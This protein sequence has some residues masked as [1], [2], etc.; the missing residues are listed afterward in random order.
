[1]RETKLKRVDVRL[2]GKRV[3]FGL[4]CKVV[5][6][7]GEPAIGALSQRGFEGVEMFALA[8]DVVG[9]FEGGAARV[10][11]VELPMRNLVVWPEFCPDVDDPSWPEI[12]EVEFL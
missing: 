12:G 8:S 4:A 2:P 11:V 10:V 9:R 7:R 6:R 5:E 3:H 1:M